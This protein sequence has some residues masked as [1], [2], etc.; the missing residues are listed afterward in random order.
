MEDIIG[1]RRIRVYGEN[2][3]VGGFMAGIDYLRVTSAKGEGLGAE[4][5]TANEL[6]GVKVAKQ[7]GLKAPLVRT[8]LLGY[9]GVGNGTVFAGSSPQGL[10]TQVSGWASEV[11]LRECPAD[12]RASR[13]DVQVSATVGDP[14]EIIAMIA[15]LASMMY[16]EPTSQWARVKRRHVQSFGSGDT[17][18]VGA[19]TSPRFIRIYN[20]S[21]ED[22]E[23]YPEPTVRFEVEYKDELARRAFFDLLRTHRPDRVAYMLVRDEMNKLGVTLPSL[24]NAPLV[25]TPK[26][27]PTDTSDEEKLAWLARQVRPS[28]IGLLHK[29]VSRDTLERILGLK[30]E[31]EQGG[32]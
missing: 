15:A 29:G 3:E 5:A 2:Y 14:D 23:N 30:E 25:N 18:Y 28:V 12:L 16:D 20:K 24:N 13:I 9:K 31:Y 6:L 21:K 10:M 27:D 8:G 11:L 1:Q 7:S 22:P 4:R 19:R 32:L 26:K 17:L